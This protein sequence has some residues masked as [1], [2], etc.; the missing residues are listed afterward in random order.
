MIPDFIS[1]IKNLNEHNDLNAI[2]NSKAA[3]RVRFDKTQKLVSDRFKRKNSA[4]DQKEIHSRIRNIVQVSVSLIEK[5]EGIKDEIEAEGKE[6]NEQTLMEKGF[7]KEDIEHINQFKD[8]ASS[9]FLQK[10]RPLI[11]QNVEIRTI[12]D[13]RTLQGFLNENLRNLRKTDLGELRKTKTEKAQSIKLKRQIE[14]AKMAGQFGLV[15]ASSKGLT[16]SYFVEWVS[17]KKTADETL[18]FSKIGVFKPDNKNTTL[19]VKIQNLFKRIFWGQLHYLSRKKRAQP[20]AEL[21]SYKTNQFLGFDIS[22]HVKAVTLDGK[23]GTM[24]KFIQGFEEA[25]DHVELFADKNNFTTEGW[26]QYQEMTLFDTLIGN[27]DRHD[28]NLLIKFEDGKIAQLKAIDNANSFPQ[29]KVGRLIKIAA[30]NRY[31]WKRFAVSEEKYDPVLLSEMRTKLQSHNIDR[32]IDSIRTDSPTFLNKKMESLLRE[33]AK[34]I[35]ALSK[36]ENLTPRQLA[37]G[38]PG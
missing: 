32:L 34:T 37:L 27:L 29:K 35:L 36:D 20:L 21:A 38:M 4:Q 26:R 25:K 2:L 1:G 9:L 5:W 18:A 17:A 19:K 3:D 22:P 12:L 13:N 8:K 33:R 30:H 16:G 15:K 10:L 31:K 14:K 23:V 7:S 6:V 11:A 28:E 24:Q